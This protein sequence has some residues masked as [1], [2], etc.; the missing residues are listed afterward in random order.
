MIF[1]NAVRKANSSGDSRK[2]FLPVLRQKPRTVVKVR[3][4]FVV[5]HEKRQMSLRYSLIQSQNP[6]CLYYTKNFK[7]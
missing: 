6:K 4:F 7:F 1:K 5:A 2:F 3:K